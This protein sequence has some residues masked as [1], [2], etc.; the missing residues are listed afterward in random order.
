MFFFSFLSLCEDQIDVA[1]PGS[2]I[3]IRNC[4][5]DMF[6]GFMRMAVDKWG[7]IT[8]DPNPESWEVGG[9]NLSEIEYELVRVDQKK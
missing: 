7:N 8:E 5:I 6:K 3:I 2:H 4:K 1:K 9:K